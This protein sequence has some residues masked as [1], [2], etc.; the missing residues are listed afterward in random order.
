MS[1]A[2][3]GLKPPQQGNVTWPRLNNHASDMLPLGFLRQR[4]EGRDGVP[5]RA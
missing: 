3:V 4:E 2:A 5:L 1:Y